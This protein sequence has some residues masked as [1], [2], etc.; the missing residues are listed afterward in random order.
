MDREQ[1]GVNTVIRLVF[2]KKLDIP[3]LTVIPSGAAYVRTRFSTKNIV[4]Q[5]V[6]K[7]R[8]G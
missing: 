4:G 5:D 2:I 1:N 7:S 6:D 3:T 8:G